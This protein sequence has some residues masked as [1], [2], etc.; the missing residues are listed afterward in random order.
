MR[1]FYLLDQDIPY[2]T[3]YATHPK[4]P[5]LYRGDSGSTE[6]TD[7]A[8]SSDVV[9]VTK[10]THISQDRI[11][12]VFQE[13]S[14]RVTTHMIR[15][16]VSQLPVIYKSGL[17]FSLKSDKVINISITHDSAFRVDSGSR[18]IFKTSEKFFSK[19]EWEWV[20]V[21]YSKGNPEDGSLECSITI[22]VQ[23]KSEEGITFKCKKKTLKN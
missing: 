5:L 12:Y 11:H 3:N 7:P 1:T 2:Y 6:V 10:N 4:Q 8:F 18:L 19:E 17:F 15:F 23:G 13:E 16:R 21:V 9:Q 22:E 20:R 14:I